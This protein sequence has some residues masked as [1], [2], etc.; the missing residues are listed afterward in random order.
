MVNPG[1]QRSESLQREL[2]RAGTFSSLMLSEERWPCQALGLPAGHAPPDQRYLCLFPDSSSHHDAA[3]TVTFPSLPN[4]PSLWAELQVDLGCW[5][6]AEL[7][8]QVR[9][10]LSGTMLMSPATALT[11]RQELFMEG[12]CAPSPSSEARTHFLKQWSSRC[13]EAPSRKEE[14]SG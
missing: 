10:A 8:Q 6:V 3:G 2:L 4:C 9:G 5:A 1:V 13:L 12:C 11:W 7:N 14:Q